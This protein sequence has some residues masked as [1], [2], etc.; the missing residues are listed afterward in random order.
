MLYEI[1][2]VHEVKGHQAQSNDGGEQP[3]RAMCEL[4]SQHVV[5]RQV[6]ASQ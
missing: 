1:H 5:E 4:I 3:M 2:T 6:L